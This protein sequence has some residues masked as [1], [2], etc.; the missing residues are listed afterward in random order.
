VRLVQWLERVGI[1]S[2]GSVTRACG[3]KAQFLRAS[4]TGALSS[5]IVD[6]YGVGLIK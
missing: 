3:M 1:E 6:I 2:Y 4:D 5:V